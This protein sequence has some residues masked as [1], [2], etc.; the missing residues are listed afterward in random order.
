M[1]SRQGLPIDVDADDR[2]F[3]GM[4]EGGNREVDLFIEILVPEYYF[5]VWSE[6]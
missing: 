3:L 6:G 4:G 1:S 5:G 2:I